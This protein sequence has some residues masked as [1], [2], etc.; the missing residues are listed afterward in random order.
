MPSSVRC[1]TCGHVLATVDLPSASVQA[2]AMSRQPGGDV[3][4]LLR[5]PDAAR[6]LSVSRSTMYQ[7]V[8]RGQVPVLRIGRSV[9]IARA[10]F[11]RLAE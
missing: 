2:T 4:L 7:L 10:A 9:R 6:L 11:E 1:P 3:P 8:A 5:I